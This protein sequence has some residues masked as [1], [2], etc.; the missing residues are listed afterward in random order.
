MV[1]SGLIFAF[2]CNFTFANTKNAVENKRTYTYGSYR[3]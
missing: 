2:F 1:Y 3:D